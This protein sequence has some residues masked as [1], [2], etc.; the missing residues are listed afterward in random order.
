MHESVPSA[1]FTQRL[2]HWT[3]P[4]GFVL[5]ATLWRRLMRNFGIEYQPERHYMRGP[6]PKWRERNSRSPQSAINSE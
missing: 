3:R 1:K 6:G 2:V 5:I 4:H